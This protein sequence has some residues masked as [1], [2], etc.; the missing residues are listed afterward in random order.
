MCRTF[1]FRVFLLLILLLFTQVLLSQDTSPSPSRTKLLPDAPS[2]FTTGTIVR[3]TFERFALFSEP[4]QRLN[5]PSQ[6][7]TIEWCARST[8][9]IDLALPEKVIFGPAKDVIN[10]HTALDSDELERYIQHIPVAGAM[11]LRISQDRHITRVLRVV[12]PEF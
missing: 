4:C 3:F 10:R 5:H 7:R 9:V 8:S 1:P 11:F 2:A 6:R 12:Q